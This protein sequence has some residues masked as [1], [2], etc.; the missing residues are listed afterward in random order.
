ME[1]PLPAEPELSP[2]EKTR[3]M[4]LRVMAVPKKEIDRREQEL[5][6]QRTTAQ[7]ERKTQK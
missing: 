3:Q 6:K 4:A 5:R 1:K 2:Y 7:R